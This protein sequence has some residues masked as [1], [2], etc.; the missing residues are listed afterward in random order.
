MFKIYR[1]IVFFL[2]T[3]IT[4]WRLIVS[5]PSGVHR[6]VILYC[7]AMQLFII[8]LWQIP[9]LHDSAFCINLHDI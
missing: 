8:D 6:I 3:I 9:F 1:V 2:K 5:R 7:F 4:P